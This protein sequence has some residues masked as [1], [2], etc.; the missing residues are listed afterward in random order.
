MTQINFINDEDHLESMIKKLENKKI[1][2]NRNQKIDL[3]FSIGK[4]FEDKKDYKKSFHYYS[5]GNY[6][7][8]K[9]LKSNIDQKI[10]LFDKVRSFF[11]NL[12][13]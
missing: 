12:G 2:L 3:L 7:K 6:L 10:I 1:N 5:K 8:R 13:T 11:S 9:T 4:G